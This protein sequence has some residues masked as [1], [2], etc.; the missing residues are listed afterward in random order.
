MW[1]IAALFL[2]LRKI[3]RAEVRV[4][5]YGGM[6]ICSNYGN[7]KSNVVLEVSM[8]D[9]CSISK[10]YLITTIFFLRFLF[11]AAIEA[12]ATTLF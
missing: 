4:I 10:V 7:I 5:C 3:K 9:C 6:W 12:S 11:L 2:N 1:K 8:S